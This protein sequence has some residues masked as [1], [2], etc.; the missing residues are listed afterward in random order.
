MRDAFIRSL[1][2]GVCVGGGGGGGGGHRSISKVKSFQSTLSHL[3]S[4]SVPAPRLPNF[5]WSI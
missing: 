4:T 1:M 3:I 2:V 5:W